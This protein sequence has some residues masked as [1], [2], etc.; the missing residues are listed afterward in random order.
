V[1][2]KAVANPDELRHLFRLSLN[3]AE[4]L[5]GHTFD[6]R[7]ADV[8]F[9]AQDELSRDAALVAAFRRCMDAAPRHTLPRL[10]IR[11]QRC[12]TFCTRMP[13]P[14][15]PLPWRRSLDGSIRPSKGSATGTY[16][17]PP[18]SSGLYEVSS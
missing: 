10:L 1:T 17:S 18:R 13:R 7:S 15:R 8:V 2:V 16:A 6:W 14:P 11:P 3:N 12:R 5:P 4:R 9:R